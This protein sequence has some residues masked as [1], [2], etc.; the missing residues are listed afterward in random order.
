[1]R[2]GISII[3]VNVGSSSSGKMVSISVIES[4]GI[5]P[6]STVYINIDGKRWSGKE[7][8]R[9]T[10]EIYEALS[11]GNL[12]D[13]SWSPWPQGT[14]KTRQISLDGFSDASSCL[15]NLI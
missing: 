3:G 4:Y 11:S 8:V 7:R 15:E 10:K 6:G 5:Y 12:M 2:D 13:I 9:V 14:R 1:M